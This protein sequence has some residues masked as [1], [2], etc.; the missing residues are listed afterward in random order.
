MLGNLR[1]KNVAVVY[2]YQV[3][4]QDDTTETLRI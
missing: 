2:L 3:N 1:L 4:Q